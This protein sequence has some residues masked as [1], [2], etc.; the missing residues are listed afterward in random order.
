VKKLP[1]RS[2]ATA[3]RVLDRAARRIL[4]EKLDGQKPRRQTEDKPSTTTTSVW[5][6][7]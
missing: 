5:G 6:L 7:E 4:K 3:Q 2:R 1:P